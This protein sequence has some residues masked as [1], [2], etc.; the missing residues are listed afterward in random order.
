MIAIPF[1]VVAAPIIIGLC[2]LV[3]FYA[4]R[5]LY[6]L[7][8]P[9]IAARI[10]F[11]GDALLDAGDAVISGIE[12]RAETL[13]DAGVRPLNEAVAAVPYHLTQW[14]NQV[15]ATLWAIVFFVERVAVGAATST[16]GTAVGGI[17]A[18]ILALQASMS[19]MTSQ[20]IPN[21][22]LS[23]NSVAAQAKDR[24][25]D[26]DRWRAG[27][28]VLTAATVNTMIGTALIP[29]QRE[30]T[31]AEARAIAAA[32]SI[33]RGVRDYALQQIDALRGALTPRVTAAEERIGVIAGELNDVLPGIRDRVGAVEIT[34]TSTL[35]QTRTLEDTFKRYMDECGDPICDTY[36]PDIPNLQ[37][38]AQ[39]FETGLIA[40]WLTDA[41]ANP[42]EAARRTDAVV[43]GPIG[44]A[45]NAIVSVAR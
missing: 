26:L 8:V 20:L 32:Q 30:I 16:V 40:A 2:L 42:R 10:P 1:V 35:T 14:G 38:V 13:I 25:D 28:T 23:I 9:V 34:A 27:V 33:E 18:T 21:L 7:V 39:I 5:A 11:I 6:E 17:N 45:V 19:L 43:T 24:L 41:I 3:A 22:Q 37:A 36:K 4:T 44:N 15:I 29:V 31:N 12:A